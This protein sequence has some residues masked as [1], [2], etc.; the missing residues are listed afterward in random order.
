[1]FDAKTYLER[2]KVLKQKFKSGILIF[3]G[4][5]E[6]PMNYP[7][8]TFHFRQ[9]SNFL[10][11]WGIDEPNMFAI[12]DVDNNREILFGD[13][14]T[15]DDIIWMGPQP[16]M[17]DKIAKI[18]VSETLP[19]GEL[20]NI[21]DIAIKNGIKYHFLPVYRAE[22][23]IEVGKLLNSLPYTINDY[24]SLELIQAV[25]AQ[26]SIKSA[27]EIREI[28]L[29]VDIA[30]QMH[31]AAMKITKPGINEY[32]ISGAI[33][34]I[35]LASDSYLS[36]PAIVTKN[37]QTL[38]NHYHGNKISEGDLIINDSG[39]ESPNHYASDITR[40]IPANGKFS[41]KHKAIYNIV[42]KAETE[43]IK[44][45][46]PGIKYREIHF[47]AAR[48][49]ADGLKEIGFMKGD[50]GKAVNAG[51]HT[52]FFPHGL[53]HM[54]GLDVHDMEGLGEDNVGYDENTKRSDQFGTA[55]LRLGKELQAGYVITV[56]PGLYFIPELIDIWK[57][58][59]KLSEFIDYDKVEEYR[60][61][62]G[63]RIEDD[64]FVTEEGYRVLG[65]PIP[66]TIEEVE[67][68]AR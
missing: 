45:I 36:F 16:K 41:D 15:I 49:I 9:D 58:E 50:M 2:R 22:T 46:K 17:T 11:Y 63:I 7:A 12:I 51:A 31:M 59:N 26:R 53:G 43:S 52:L 24:A 35:A 55:Y 39:A 64:V 38:H 25:V 61:F 20:K 62:G 4:N 29:A 8:N 23:K 5:V 13:D 1:M 67:K 65:T 60:D 21:I 40:T 28:E 66:K 33:E 19:M 27:E 47:A 48:I 57:S 44:M 18:G 6:S 42:L 32:E 54:L 14:F 68:M 34:G 56:E 3:A 37:G 30:A 10:Y